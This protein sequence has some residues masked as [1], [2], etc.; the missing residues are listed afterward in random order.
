ML[1][2]LLGLLWRRDQTR[3]ARAFP[4]HAPSAPLSAGSSQKPRRNGHPTVL[5]MQA[6]S[7]PGATRR[8]CLSSS[9]L[10]CACTFVIHLD[11]ARRADNAFRHLERRRDRA[12]GKQPF[13]PGQGYRVYHQ[14]QRHAVWAIQKLINNFSFHIR[15]LFSP[16]LQFFRRLS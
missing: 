12:I 4:T 11:D 7:K 16:F 9:D 5:A 8:E 6:R 14:P 13:S 2:G 1:R 10:D 15:Q 3:L